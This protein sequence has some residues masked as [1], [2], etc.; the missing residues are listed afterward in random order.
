[1]SVDPEEMRS[2]ERGRE[3]SKITPIYIIRENEKWAARKAWDIIV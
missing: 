2:L 1:M 3:A